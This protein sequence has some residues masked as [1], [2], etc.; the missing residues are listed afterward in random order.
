MVDIYLNDEKLD[1]TLEDEKTVDDLL[2]SL[3]KELSKSEFVF[4]KVKVDEKEYE[5]PHPSPAI[6]LNNVKQIDVFSI[7][8]EEL[9]V[10][11]SVELREMAYKLEN[12][13]D[14]YQNKIVKKDEINNI[15]TTIAWMKNS[16]NHLGQILQTNY[17]EILLQ[18]LDRVEIKL[19]DILNHSLDKKTEENIKAIHSFLVEMKNHF[20]HIA[21]KA[22]IM[23]FDK[24]ISKQSK[25][26]NQQNQK[27]FKK[28]LFEYIQ[29]QVLLIPEEIQTGKTQMAFIRLQDFMDISIIFMKYLETNNDLEKENINKVKS[30]LLEIESAIK[31][32]NFIEVSDLLEYE[33]INKIE[34][35]IESA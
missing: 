20:D 30:L 11:C 24:V 26:L 2:C 32:N 28:S 13:F 23:C 14:N 3:E 31:D 6:T 5:F 10:D 21:L 29:K 1:V 33:F 12:Y 35:L 25:K 9:I 8:Q 17:K 16:V 7:S 18:F 19:F 4:S 15:L 22:Y 34:P 27:A